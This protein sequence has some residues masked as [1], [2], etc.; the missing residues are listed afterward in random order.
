MNIEKRTW[1]WNQSVI[2]MMPAK[3]KCFAAEQ[4]PQMFV[5]AEKR[6][7]EAEKKHLAYL[8]AER[9]LFA[10]VDAQK[11]CLRDD[12]GKKMVGV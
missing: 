10:K 3:S 11:K 7:L 6:C 9:R 8:E 12:A 5:A 2:W 4:E 1:R